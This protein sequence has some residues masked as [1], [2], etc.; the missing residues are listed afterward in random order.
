MWP[1]VPLG[2][3]GAPR[4]LSASCGPAPRDGRAIDRRLAPA[5]PRLFGVAAPL[6]P[7]VDR[8][9]LDA[10]VTALLRLVTVQ[11]AVLKRGHDGHLAARASLDDLPD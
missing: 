4:A 8:R 11:A 1:T 5:E 3:S 7:S 10:P 2:R 6:D 9:H